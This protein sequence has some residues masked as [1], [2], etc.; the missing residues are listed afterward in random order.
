MS[1]LGSL[2]GSVLGNLLG[3]RGGG[4]NPL[5]NIIMGMLTNP[6]S[7]GL[8]GMLQQLNQGGLGHQADS[9]VSTGQNLPVQGAD[10]LKAFGQ[11]KVQQMAQQSG[12]S[13]DQ[14]LSGLSTQLPQVVDKLT[15]NGRLPDQGSIEGLL[16]ELGGRTRG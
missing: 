3:G 4:T 1:F 15:P 11:S 7:G 10:L 9:W 14:L 8:Q 2:L 12:L 6:Q 5:M 13:M 16:K